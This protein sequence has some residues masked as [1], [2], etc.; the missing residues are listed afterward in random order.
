MQVLRWFR[1]LV[2]I[3]T[4][5]ALPC[6]SFSQIGVGVSITVAPPELPVY[7]Q[8]ICPGPN[9]LWTPGYWAWG[10]GGYYWVPG[11]WV[12]APAVGLLWT[13]GYWGWGNG[14]YLWHAGYWG[15]QVGF[16]GG[17]NYGYGYSGTGFYGGRW[18]GG[19]FSYNTAVMRVNTTIIRNTYVDRT[20][21]VNNRSVSRVS[22]NGGRGGIEARASAQQI[23]AARDRRYGPTNLQAQQEHFARDNK[24]NWA[25][26][27][28]GNPRYAAL[29]KPATSAAE[30]NRAA[31]ARGVRNVTTETTRPAPNA[32]PETR[33]GNEA[34]PVTRP[35]NEARPETRPAAR[36]EATPA[37]PETRPTPTSR[38]ET[39]PT[40]EARPTPRPS[41][42]HAARPTPETRPAPAAR[43]ESRP[44]P[45]AR[46]APQERPAATPRPE[47]RPAPVNRPEPAARPASPQHESAPRPSSGEKPPRR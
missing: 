25:S 26:E 28:H 38:P 14:V 2:L 27:N 42:A 11:T 23:A 47:S 12:M 9:Y 13:P 36:P 20:V 40:S 45:A 39:R 1:N 29:Q 37:R 32:R 34:R 7:D 6:A 33:P 22:Y 16:Y 30:F 31:P 8:P 19:Y 17:V 21:I 41:P 35:T 24:A 43:P 15:P 4:L 5:G 3:A 44:V 10:P 46:P 18:N